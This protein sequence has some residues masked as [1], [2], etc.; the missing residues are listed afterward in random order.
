MT[1]KGAQ[2]SARTK[3]VARL[4][5]LFGWSITLQA[6]IFLAIDIAMRYGAR[7]LVE[8]IARGNS[9]T[10]FAVDAVVTIAIVV[11]AADLFFAAMIGFM[12]ARRLLWAIVRATPHPMQA[13]TQPI[14]IAALC[15]AAVVAVISIMRFAS[16]AQPPSTLIFGWALELVRDAAIVWLFWFAARRAT[17]RSVVR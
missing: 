17:A 6:A 10:W 11:V 9:G 5:S 3:T 16:T 14:P 2:P 7:V 4:S 15:A 8:G 1:P 12:G 13:P